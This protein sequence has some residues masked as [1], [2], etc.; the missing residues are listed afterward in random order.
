MAKWETFLLFVS[1]FCAVPHSSGL[2]AEYERVI[3]QTTGGLVEGERR[4]PLEN[5]NKFWYY[6]GGISIDSSTEGRFNVST[7]FYFC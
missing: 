5:S 3:I 6:F 1:S 4:S 2:R 7:L